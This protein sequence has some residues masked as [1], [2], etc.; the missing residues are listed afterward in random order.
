MR[1]KISSL[2]TITWK[3]GIDNIFNQ[4]A[5]TYLWDKL[6]R[7]TSDRADRDY[8]LN[9]FSQKIQSA[10]SPKDVN[11]LMDMKSRYLQKVVDLGE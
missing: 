4:R 6:N 10:P 7:W 11:R 5:H 2:D 9:K 1:P 8:I 3:R